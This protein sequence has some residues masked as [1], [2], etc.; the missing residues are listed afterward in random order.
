MNRNGSDNKRR[1]FRIRSGE[2]W[3]GDADGQSDGAG[4]RREQLLHALREC[5]GFPGNEAEHQIRQFEEGVE[6]GF[7]PDASHP[8]RRSRTT[9]H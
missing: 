6:S 8:G 9:W 1:A 2:N 7:E 3:K 5:Y 4:S